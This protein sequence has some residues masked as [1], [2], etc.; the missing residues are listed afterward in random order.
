M[1]IFEIILVFK[2]GCVCVCVCVC[3]SVDNY[4]SPCFL[5]IVTDD[6]L[7]LLLILNMNVVIFMLQ[8]Q[9]L[10]NHRAQNKKEIEKCS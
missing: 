8:F 9:F 10:C 3:V 5:R 2:K 7:S 4:N 6:N 1:I